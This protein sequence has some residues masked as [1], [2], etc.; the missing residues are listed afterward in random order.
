MT[1]TGSIPSGWAAPQLARLAHFGVTRSV[2]LH[3]H[4]LPGVD[5]GPRTLDDAVALCRMLVR[6]GIT[7]VIATP[8]QL[9]RFDGSNWAEDVRRAV[10]D[11]RETLVRERV[12]LSVYPGAEVRIDER[13]PRLLGDDRALTLADRREFLLIE[14][15]TAMAV[16]AAAVTGLIGAWP[17]VVLAHAE[18]YDVMRRDPAKAEEWVEA[19]IALQVNAASLLPDA[20]EACREVALMWLDQGWVSLVA[21]DAHSTGA[22]RP[23]MTEAIEFVEAEYGADVARKICLENPARVL[24]LESISA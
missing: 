16:G 19:G 1:F 6:D 9:G 10:A 5:D 22:R 23:R 2:D 15:P 14:L 12:P 17:T 7:D 11:L 18:R 3:C 21:T 8:H 20:P 24:G 13:I 4:C